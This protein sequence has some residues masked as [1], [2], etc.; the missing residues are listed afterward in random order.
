MTD[1]P[2]ICAECFYYNQF[3]KACKHPKTT[4]VDLVTGET[5]FKSCAE[6]R[7]EFGYC[8]FKG[9]LWKAKNDFWKYKS[10]N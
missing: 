3:S 10:L 1:K 5:T 6:M 4:K 7:K 2:K 8:G 9:Y